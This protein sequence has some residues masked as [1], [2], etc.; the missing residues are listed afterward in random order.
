MLGN[1]GNLQYVHSIQSP[2]I[3]FSHFVCDVH[4]NLLRDGAVSMSE[5]SA[6]GLDRDTGLR[7]EGR[8]CMTERMNGQRGAVDLRDMLPEVFAVCLVVHR[9]SVS[10]WKEQGRPDAVS[11]AD[12][13]LPEQDG[14]HECEQFRAHVN[15]TLGHLRLRRLHFPG[16]ER[17]RFVYR[18][19]LRG[20]IH[21][22]YG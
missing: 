21:V 13:F 1:L 22:F 16:G 17:I 20:H 19:A 12:L 5:L 7:H 18:D 9:A 15:D 14:L 8:V 4:V 11:K 3:R 2:V 6:D 10:P